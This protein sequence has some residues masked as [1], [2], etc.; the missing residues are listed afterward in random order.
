[1][2]TLASLQTSGK[3][4]AVLGD[5]L[6]LG[7]YSAEEHK[8]AGVLATQSCN[9][10]ITVG[11]RAKLMNGSTISFNSSEEAGEYLKGI[12]GA[13]D[14]IFIK[15][16]QSIRMERVTKALMTEP[17]RAGELLVRQEEEWLNRG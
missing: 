10:L 1:L 2:K 3:K 13:G 6:E 5:M 11:Q 7:S 17:E 9:I 4:I 12:I 15:G 16:S 8:K 14:I